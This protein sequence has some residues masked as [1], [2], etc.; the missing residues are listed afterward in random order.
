MFVAAEAEVVTAFFCRRCRA[1]AVNDG[2]I[3]ELVLMQFADRSEQYG[4]QTTIGYPAPEN[5]V[6]AR[7]MNF[8]ATGR[9]LVDR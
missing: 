9:I 1:I 8:G 4:V 2:R 6:D 7:G 5:A 3:E